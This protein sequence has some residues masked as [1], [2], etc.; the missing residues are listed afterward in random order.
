[1]TTTTR[2]EENL[3]RSA[4]ELAGSS[5]LLGITD[6]KKVSKTPEQLHQSNLSRANGLLSRLN[7]C[8]SACESALPNWKRRF[9]KEVY[10]KVRDGLQSCRAT[11]DVILDDLEDVRH[12]P[13]DTSLH[14]GVMEKLNKVQAAMMD[15]IGALT[16][17]MKKFKDEKDVKKEMKNDEPRPAS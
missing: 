1:M 15:H 13:G 3:K 4:T 17:V 16:D 5:S 14:D 12:L 8:I 2:V 6:N 7:K 10:C 11:K 9:D